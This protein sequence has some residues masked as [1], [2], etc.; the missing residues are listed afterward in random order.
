MNNSKFFLEEAK[1][2]HPE[3]LLAPGVFYLQKKPV[4]RCSN[5][6]L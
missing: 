3:G 1:K 6:P 5:A 2:I 4:N